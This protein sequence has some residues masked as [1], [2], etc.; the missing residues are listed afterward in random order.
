MGNIASFPANNNLAAIIAHEFGHVLGLYDMYKGPGIA[1]GYETGSIMVF[2]F[3]G[4]VDIR[5]IKD[6]I[7]QCMGA[8]Q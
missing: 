8:E 2:G 1:S 6:V 4:R 3:T 5:T 7:E